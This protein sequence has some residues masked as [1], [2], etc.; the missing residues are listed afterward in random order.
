MTLYE[1]R[2]E[3]GL[4]TTEIAHTIGVSYPTLLNWENGKT[5]PDAIALKKLLELYGKT[6]EELDWTSLKN[7]GK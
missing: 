4:G 1:M 6:N 2:K 3:S 7:S 5:I